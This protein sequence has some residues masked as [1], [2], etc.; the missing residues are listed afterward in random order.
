MGIVSI[1]RRRAFA[2]LGLLLAAAPIGACGGGDG[3]GS[4]RKPLTKAA[5]IA[6]ADRICRDF[7]ASVRKLDSEMAAKPAGS[8]IS[9]YV[10]IFE[11]VLDEAK[12]AS[13]RFQALEPPTQ[14]RATID[15]YLDGQRQGLTVVGQILAAA[16]VGDNRKLGALLG[17]ND[18]LKKRQAALARDYGFKA[19]GTGTTG[20]GT[21]Y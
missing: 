2:V 20:A 7:S 18:A 11:H 9:A 3:G 17:N 10:P 19:C 16:K 14:D 5:Y 4:P 1:S 13:Q 15:R 6:S 8:P 12:R 21:T